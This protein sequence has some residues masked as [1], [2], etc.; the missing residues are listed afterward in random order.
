MI[1]RPYLVDKMKYLC[2]DTV[3]PRQPFSLHL[4]Q[5]SIRRALYASTKVRAR[6]MGNC[7]H[8]LKYIGSPFDR[9]KGLV[10]ISSAAFCKISVCLR[11]H[12][13]LFFLLLFV[14]WTGNQI[15]GDG[16][17]NDV[18]NP[19]RIFFCWQNISMHRN[20]IEK[21]KYVSGRGAVETTPDSRFF[22][23]WYWSIRF[24]VPKTWFEWEPL[25]FVMHAVVDATMWNKS[26]VEKKSD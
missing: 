19:V 1:L 20:I 21:H 14:C 17:W 3:N 10:A 26:V 2:S 23:S 24:C 12:R 22:I 4:I 9:Q 25:L 15:P 7:D 13:W 5:Y 16:R 8:R 6:G 11:L 18:F